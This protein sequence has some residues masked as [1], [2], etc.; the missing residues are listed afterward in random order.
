M[1]LQL[2]QLIQ[3]W[4]NDKVLRFVNFMWKEWNKSQDALIR[5][6]AQK[7]PAAEGDESKDEADNM[8]G[9]KEQNG[10][11]APATVVRAAK[12]GLALIGNVLHSSLHTEPYER[13]ISETSPVV[14]AN[15]TMLER[16]HSGTIRVPPLAESHRGLIE[17]SVF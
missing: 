13:E 14:P 17:D 12:M 9:S 15:A 5:A 2:P 10:P 11:A 6:S 4:S 3:R 8:S 1:T 7:P 16:T